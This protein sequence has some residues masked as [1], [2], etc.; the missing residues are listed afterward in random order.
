MEPY[1]FEH[2]TYTY[3]GEVKPAVED[4][5]FA[6][7]PGEFIV[8]CGASGSGKTT[9]L[10]QLKE[11]YPAFGFVMQNPHTQTVTDTVCHELAFGMENQGIPPGK[12][13]KKG[14]A[15]GLEAVAPFYD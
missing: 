2:I 15:A 4:V 8:V 13:G 7:H 14:R 10:R 12:P 3:P 5:S 9:L 11:K 1:R 6:V